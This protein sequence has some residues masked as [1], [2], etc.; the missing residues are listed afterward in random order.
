[1]LVDL[2]CSPI[3]TSTGNYLFFSDNTLVKFNSGDFTLSQEDFDKA[4]VK[5][6]SFGFFDGDKSQ[7]HR[8][9]GELQRV[10]KAKFIKNFKG[11]VSVAERFFNEKDNLN[12]ANTFVSD[13]TNESN[14]A[15]VQTEEELDETVKIIRDSVKNKP[16]NLI[17]SDLKWKLLI[18]SILRGKNLMIVGPTGCGKTMA[19]KIASKMLDRELHFFNMGS[20][21]DPRLS[22]IGNTSFNP[23]DGTVFNKSEFVKAI[24][25]PNA[26]VLLDELT[27]IHPEGMN[28][29]MT[30][31]DPGQRYLRLD[32]SEK[33]EVI[34]VADGVSFIATANIG[35][36]YTS[37]RMLDRALTDR[38]QIFEMDVL[39]AEQERTLLYSLFGSIKQD[40]DRLV[41]LSTSIKSDYFSDNPKFD[42]FISTRVMIETA[43][44]ITDGFEFMEAI[45]MVIFPYFSAE[46]GVDSE[47][48]YLK[49]ILQKNDGT[50]IVEDSNE[51]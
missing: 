45:E 43:E 21:Q 51:F 22:L 50:Q 6:L 41:E 12:F 3:K 5:N 20:T 9:R 7:I 36:E 42:T 27:R 30:V 1:M 13:F 18:R 49:Q 11:D 46:G 10:R 26:V 4:Y 19:A 25:T 17:I 15:V 28:I 32:E 8:Y 34:K 38:F 33:T 48:T 23:E 29:L 24:T 40:V 39:N 37:T 44:L 16:D 14:P 35:N 47:R 31:L 2:F